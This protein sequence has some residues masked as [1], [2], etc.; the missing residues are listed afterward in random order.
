M[1]ARSKGLAENLNTL[2]QEPVNAN[3][4]VEPL[5]NQIRELQK[6]IA[7]NL[8][9]EQLQAYARKQQLLSWETQH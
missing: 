1:V 3:G 2:Q 6:L 7:D 4:V 9:N 5:K 8:T